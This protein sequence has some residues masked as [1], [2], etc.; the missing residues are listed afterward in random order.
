MGAG[1]RASLAIVAV[2]FSATGDVDADSGGDVVEPTEVRAARPISLFA[3]LSM[4]YG[5]IPIPSLRATLNVTPRLAFQVQAESA[6]VLSQ[7]EIGAIW[8]FGRGSAS[9]FAVARAGYQHY[10]PLGD[11]VPESPA[12]ATA[13]A[14]IESVRESGWGMFVEATASVVAA[15]PDNQLPGWLARLAFGIGRRF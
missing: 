7:A 10:E 11:G 8:Y 13:G 6:V 5:F 14:G 2:L 15:G 3:G 9:G 12:T 4:Y 1:T